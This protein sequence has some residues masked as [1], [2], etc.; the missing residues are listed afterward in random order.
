MH[1]HD[2]CLYW[3]EMRWMT[4]E[5]GKLVHMR[6]RILE[7]CNFDYGSTIDGCHLPK[8]QGQDTQVV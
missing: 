8:M 1:M 3:H 6:D 4:L 5:E 2:M 7:C